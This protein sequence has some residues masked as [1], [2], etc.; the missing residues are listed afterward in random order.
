MWR[1]K[2]LKL[3]GLAMTISSDMVMESVLEQFPDIQD[4]WDEHLRYWD[5]ESPGLGLDLHELVGF[6]RT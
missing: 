6:T 3:A 4:R 2:C 5:G 1:R